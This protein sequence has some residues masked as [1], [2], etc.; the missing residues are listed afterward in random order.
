MITVGR[1]FDVDLIRQ[2][3][4]HPKI[5]AAATDDA[6][7]KPEDFEPV[8]HP[9]LIYLGV[10]EDGEFRGLFLFVR[11][12]AVLWEVHTRILPELWGEKALVATKEARAWMWKAGAW[13][14]FT[15]IPSLN[16]KAVQFA[17]KSGMEF[18]GV[19]KDSWGKDG[20]LQDLFILGV[21]R[22]LEV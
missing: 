22:P 6:A 3:M 19:N 10:F 4:T 7:G 14:I 5:W 17:I 12:N 11:Q 15:T 18:C 13:R 16:S 2:A 20:K 8:I 9:G 1:I 21:S